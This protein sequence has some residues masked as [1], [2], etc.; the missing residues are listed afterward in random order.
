MQKTHSFKTTAL[1]SAAIAVTMIFSGCNQQDLVYQKSLAELNTKAQ[2]MLQAG[3]VNGAVSRLEAAHD[4]APDEPNTTMNLAVAYQMQGNHDKAI[5]LFQQL[6]DKPGQ[7]KADIEK[8]L[9]ITYEAKADEL[10]AKSK[11]P[12]DGVKPDPAQM[13]QLKQQSLDSYQSA[14][15]HYQASMDLK[16]SDEI[17]KQIAG[18]QAK[19]HPSKDQPAIQ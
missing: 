6:L 10:D 4:L 18:I 3:D 15:N 2:A 1:L 13:E 12:E 14:M 16:K 9:G 11:G 19:L 7:D 17:E 8:N 5:M